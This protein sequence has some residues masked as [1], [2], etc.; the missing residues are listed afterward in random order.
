MT[1]VRY[2]VVLY[3]PLYNRN[4]TEFGNMENYLNIFFSFLFINFSWADVL[5]EVN[6]RNSFVPWVLFFLCRNQTLALLIFIR[7]LLHYKFAFW[8]SSMMKKWIL[9]HL[10]M[11][12]HGEGYSRRLFALTSISAFLLHWTHK[13][14]FEQNIWTLL[15]SSSSI[16]ALFYIS[17]SSETKEAVHLQKADIVLLFIYL[18]NMLCIFAVAVMAIYFF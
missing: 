10:I 1:D 13:K 18:I 9:L 15:L 11:H 14:Y 2:N 4:H 7:K 3:F 16:P 12:V 5:Y 6:I 17:E 8:N